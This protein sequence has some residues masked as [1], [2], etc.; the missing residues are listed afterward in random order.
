MEYNKFE[1]GC[2][3]TK[4]PSQCIL[5]GD[6]EMKS[7]IGTSEQSVCSSTESRIHEVENPVYLTKDEIRR[8]YW[9]K[10]VLLT[11]VQ[12]TPKQ[13]RIDGGIVRFYASTDAIDELWQKLAELRATEGDSVLESCGVEY[14]GD[15]HLNLYV[16]GEVS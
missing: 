14:M 13:D 6:E 10:Q 11:N 12:M 16:G 2:G 3:D 1:C 5:R 7:M 9:G 4:N 8:E 15:V